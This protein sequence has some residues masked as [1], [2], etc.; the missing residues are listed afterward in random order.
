MAN[1]DNNNIMTKLTKRKQTSYHS[2]RF[3][4]E[5]QQW[6]QEMNAKHFYLPAF[7]QNSMRKMT[8]QW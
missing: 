1:D 5:F 4:L 3:K 6:T 8:Q 7:A 2:I